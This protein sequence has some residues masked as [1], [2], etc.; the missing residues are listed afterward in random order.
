[1]ALFLTRAGGGAGRGRG[2]RPGTVL[3]AGVRPP[4]P[5]RSPDQVPASTTVPF[6]MIPIVVALMPTPVSS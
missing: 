1:M 4:T 5:V 3:G 6:F 2:G